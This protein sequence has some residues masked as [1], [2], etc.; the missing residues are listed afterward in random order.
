MLLNTAMMVKN[1]DTET[2]IT[3]FLLYD[4]RQK[5]KASPEKPTEC[6]SWFNTFNFHALQYGSF[7]F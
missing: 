7:L 4:P 2:R 6:K 5:V 1:K 3:Y